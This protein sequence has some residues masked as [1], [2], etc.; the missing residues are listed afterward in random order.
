M[1]RLGQRPDAPKL[2]EEAKGGSEL[3]GRCGPCARDGL[4]QSCECGRRDEQ[5]EAP[6]FVKRRPLASVRIS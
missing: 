5:S 1:L 2:G 4:R 3:D 6:N